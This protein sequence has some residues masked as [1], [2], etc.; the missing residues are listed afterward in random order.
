LAERQAYLAHRKDR[1]EVLERHWANARATI[2]AMP[3]N[4][5]TRVRLRAEGLLLGLNRLRT[6]RLDREFAERHPTARERAATRAQ[7][8][9]EYVEIREEIADLERRLLESEEEDEEAEIFEL[10]LPPGPSRRRDEDDDESNGGRA[11]GSARL[12]ER[13][14]RASRSSFQI[15]V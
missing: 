6:E 14:W 8:H 1:H 15:E 3:G 7:R 9:R 13:S 4:V 12:R 2:R 10:D 5:R 11:R